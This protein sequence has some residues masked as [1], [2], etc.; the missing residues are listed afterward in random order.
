MLQAMTG[1]GPTTAP[2]HSP[3]FQHLGSIGGYGEVGV[4]HAAEQGLADEG[5]SGVPPRSRRMF[6]TQKS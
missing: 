3:A 6:F 4:A 2:H 5:V 1:D